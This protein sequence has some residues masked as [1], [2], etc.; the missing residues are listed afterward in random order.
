MNLS[1]FAEAT[2]VLND[3]GFDLS[4]LYVI[5]EYQRA[6]AKGDVTI[7]T[8][9]KNTVLSK[10]VMLRRIKKLVEQGVFKRAERDSDLR[11]RVLVDGPRMGPIVEYFKEI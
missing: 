6:K 8:L 9:T 5:S 4:D 7:M 10:T 1:N 3:D 2:R 11:L